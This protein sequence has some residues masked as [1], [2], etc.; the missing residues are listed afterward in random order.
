MTYTNVFGGN[1][2]YPSDVSY[3]ALELDADVVLQ[4]PL[5]TATTADVVARIMDITSNGAYS[6]FMPD[7]TQTGAGQTVLFNNVGLTTFTVKD[8]AGGTLASVA[9]G[10]QWQIYLTGVATAA[11]TWEVFQFGA[12]TATVQASALAGLGLAANGN[13]LQQTQLVV[14]FSAD[15]TVGASD[16]ASAYVWTGGLGTLTL[17]SATSATNGWFLAVRN[18]GVGN[19]IIAAAGADTI[20]GASALTLRPG[21]SATINTDGTSFWTV[22]LGQDP[23]F[24]FDYTSVNVAGESGDYTLTGAELNRIAYQFVGALAGNVVIIVPDTTQQYWVANDTTGGSYTLSVGTA[25]QVSP[26]TVVRGSRG[27]YYC[28]GSS[29]VNAATAG[30]S[31]PISIADGGTGATTTTDARINLGGT[32]VGIAVFT[33]A[34]A[35]AGRS[36]LSAAGSGANSDITSLTGLTTPL[37]VLQGG[38][39]VTT[40][41]GTGATVRAVSPALTTPDLGTPSAL[42]LTSATGLPLTTGVTGTL[43]VASGGTGITAFGTG[44]ATALGQNVT[45]S[46]GI[47]L[48]T[49]PSFTTPILGTPTSGNMANVTGLPLTTGVTGTLPV[50]NGGTGATTLTANNVVLGNGTSAVQFVAPGASGNVLTSNGTTW[51]STAPAR[52]STVAKS[53]GYTVLAADYNTTFDCTGSFT[54]ALTAAAT[55]GDGFVFGVEN[56]GT[57][58]ITLNPDGAEV[59]DGYATILVYPGE[60][61]TVRCDGSAFFTFGRQQRLLVQS[62]TTS[63]AAQFDFEAM[64]ADPQLGTLEFGL[65]AVVGDLAGNGVRVRFKYAGSYVSGGTDYNSTAGGAASAIVLAG[66]VASVVVNGVL[67]MASPLS[68][69]AYAQAMTGSVIASS[70]SATTWG[71]LNS[72][73]A[74]N[75]EGVRFFTNGGGNF[76]SGVINCYLNRAV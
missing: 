41:T 27:I 50:A 47:A 54:L 51:A 33:A 55:L 39:G 32:S 57:G 25:A 46:G 45:G 21:D 76:Q 56:T 59:I 3:L 69:T 62:T 23:V 24:A 63:G 17:P 2:I 14:T 67:V 35:A 31:T 71:V 65:G 11:G 60:N 29:V 53:S 42:V 19:L 68:N 9:A 75:C 16:R 22:G 37:S 8:S 73:Q 48:A 74:G 4:W 58:I 1:T 44:V 20:N 36:A 30:I 10:T 18:G 49:S 34:N 38:T 52:G 61:F 7:A 13:V 6:I 28:N 64:F 12:S 72:T 40:S 26:V 43:P 66:A 15:F 5:E 70:A